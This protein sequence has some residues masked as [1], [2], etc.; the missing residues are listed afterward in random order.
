MLPLHVFQQR[1][2]DWISPAALPTGLDHISIRLTTYNRSH[3][4]L[5]GTLH[6]PIVW[7]PSGPGIQPC[8]INSYWY[9]ADTPSPAIL[10]L[11]SCKRLV[12]VKMNCAVTVMQPSTKPQ[13]L[14]LA[15]TTATKVKPATALT[16]AKS[17]RSTDDLIKEF[18]N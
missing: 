8:K 10:G 12:I 14:I 13:N 11:P 9:I 5:Y 18:P 16:I 4:P 15:S 6:G 7:Q 3:I 17:N 1:Y 2:P